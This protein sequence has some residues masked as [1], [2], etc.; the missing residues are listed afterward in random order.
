M[1]EI[2]LCAKELKK[3]VSMFLQFHLLLPSHEASLFCGADEFWL[4][5]CV[6]VTSPKRI[7]LEGLG[8]RLTETE[9]ICNV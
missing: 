7:D 3:V 2:L 8:K 4:T 1:L 6:R 5:R 9:Q